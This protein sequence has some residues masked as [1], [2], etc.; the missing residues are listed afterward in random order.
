MANTT[1]FSPV[2]KVKH[3]R[4]I[5]PLTSKGSKIK[6]TMMGHYGRKKGKQV[7]Y[8]SENKGVL[9]GGIA[10][11]GGRRPGKMGRL[12]QMIMNKVGQK[13]GRRVGGGR[14]QPKRQYIGK[15]RY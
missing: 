12:G 9:G 1:T 5:V 7:F 15:Y 6:S 10:K 2:L 11:R 13:G 8:A 14:P 4:G 3:G